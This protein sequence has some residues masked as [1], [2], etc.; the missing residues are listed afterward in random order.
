MS[1]DALSSTLYSLMSHAY[2]AGYGRAKAEQGLTF[3][4]AP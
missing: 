4:V 1:A 3:Q 2:A